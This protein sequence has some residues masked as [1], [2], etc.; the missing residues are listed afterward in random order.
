MAISTELFSKIGVLV[1]WRMPPI[2]FLNYPE[3]DIRAAQARANSIK[4]SSSVFISK[5]QHFLYKLQYN[6]TR[7]FFSKNK[8]AIAVVWQGLNGSRY[9]FIEAAKDAGARTL[10]LELGPF[11]GVVTC[12]RVGVNFAN[13]LTRDIDYYKEWSKT[14]PDLK[15][16]INIAA[17]I[18]SRKS[19]Y[20]PKTSNESIPTDEL[21]IFAPLQVPNDSQLRLFGQNFNTI[22]KF[23][24]ALILASSSLPKGWH[25]R[26]KEHP[27]TQVSFYEYISKNRGTAKIYVDNQTDTIDLIKLSQGVITVNSSVGLEA[28]LFEKA[29]ISCGD[30]FWALDGLCNKAQTL[31]KIEALFTNPGLLSFDSRARIAFL[32]FLIK[33]YYI[34]RSALIAGHQTEEIDKIIE[35]LNRTYQNK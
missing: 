11:P 10:Y 34:N 32:N 28:M 2:G 18:S 25:I 3:S 4:K 13:S 20:P 23:I 19:P 9:S 5:A 21:F 15:S 29:V 26:I 8:D 6:G 27:T 30:C 33:D 31:S 7:A 16:L 22:T 1:H 35:R 14:N 17:G 24:D 12:D